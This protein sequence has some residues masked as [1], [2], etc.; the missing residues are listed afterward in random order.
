MR[1]KTY[2][3]VVLLLASLCCVRQGA[4]TQEPQASADARFLAAYQLLIKADDTRNRGEHVDAAGLYNKALSAYAQL[5]ARYPDW[6]PR[7]VQFRIAYCDGQL[8]SVLK[9]AGKSRKDLTSS[10]PTSPKKNKIQGERL[11]EIK[12]EAKGLLVKGKAVEARKILIEAMNIDPDDISIRLLMGVTQC[13]AGE[14]QDAAYVL[15][16]LVE[17]SPENA[18]ARVVLG[19]AYFGLG[20]IESAKAET[21]LALELK[22]NIH[23]AHYNMVQILLADDPPNIKKAKLHY[24]KAVEC[25]AKPDKRLEGRLGIDD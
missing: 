19:T 7:V 9:K 14:F 16:Q 24:A 25:G 21:S 3:F 1:R 2:L 8:D 22:S 15:K 13:Q 5:A 11:D 6:K 4:M 17:E 20:Q 18:Q 10:A 23:E 12:K